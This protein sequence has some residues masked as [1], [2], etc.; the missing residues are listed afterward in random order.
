[1]SEWQLRQTS[2]QLP[3]FTDLEQFL[4]NRVN[5]YEAGEIAIGSAVNDKYSKVKK[6]LKEPPEYFVH[7][8]RIK[9]M[10][11]LEEQ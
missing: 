9:V 5:A 7:I 4:S 8:V 11:Y 6:V 10:Y 3:T 1:V 2:K